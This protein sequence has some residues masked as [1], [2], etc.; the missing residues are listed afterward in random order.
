MTEAVASTELL[1]SL[2]LTAAA[3]QLAIALLTEQGQPT[4]VLDEHLQTA[5]AVIQKA[6]SGQ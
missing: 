5:R 4:E 1:D 3:L 2:K 6:N